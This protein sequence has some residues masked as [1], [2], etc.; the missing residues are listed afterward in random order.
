MARVTAERVKE[1]KRELLEAAQQVL[2]EEGYSGLS[3]R[4]VAEAAGTQMSQIQYHFGSKE[5]MILALF[6]YLN[7]QL[8]DRQT[9]TFNNPD[10][11]V[12]EKWAL[13]CDYLDQDI[14]S[15]YV[16]VLMEL[17]AAGW[18]N[19]V[20]G[21]AVS[22]AYAEWRDLILKLARE[23]ERQNGSLGPFTAEEIGALV[24]AAFI[25]TEAAI[26]LGYESPEIPFR[27][28]LRR[29]GKIIEMFDRTERQE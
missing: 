7:S 20:I 5:G 11:S 27:D 15:G 18:S 22:S 21:A 16:R 17:T 2:L 19:P 10:L 28:A 9:R 4:R 29:F 26:M 3:T 8:I 23:V 25:G 6:E 24:S 1:T 12:S 14:G 13:S